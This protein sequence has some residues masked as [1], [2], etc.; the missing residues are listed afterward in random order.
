MHRTT[1]FWRP[2]VWGTLLA[3]LMS[4]LTPALAQDPCRSSALAQEAGRG[5]VLLVP[6]GSTVPLQLKSRK[7][8]KTVVNPKDNVIEIRTVGGDPTTVRITGLQ[9]G[10]TT[11]ELTDADERKE[12]YEVTVQQDVEYLKTLIRRVVPT[13]NV[14]PIPSANNAIILTGTVTRAEDIG[15]IRSLAQSLG[16]VQVIDGMRVGGVLQVQLDVVIASVSRT[17]TR[18]V[19]FDWAVNSQNSFFSNYVAGTQTLPGSVGSAGTLGSF[20]L[21]GL[22]ATPTSSSSFLFGV[23]HSGW[24]LLGFLQALK[25]EGLA[26]FLTQPSLV[27][28]SGRPAF[29]NV[30]GQQA[31]PVVGGIGGATGVS[32][33]P[34]G[35]QLTFLPIV[36]GNGK[37]YMEVAPNITDLDPAFGVVLAGN[38]VPGRRQE[39]V[40]TTV[41]LESGQTFVIG[42]LTRHVT[43]ANARKLPFLGELPFVG[44]FFGSRV[45]QDE[46]E[47]LVILVTPHLVD[48]QDCAQVAK[49]LPGQET[50]RAD[51]FE[52]YLEGILEA[53]RGARDVF[54]NRH[55]I[56]A[57]KNSPS[58]EVFPCAGPHINDA[59]HR[60]DHGPAGHSVPAGQPVPPP[61]ALH[62][63]SA[64]ACTTGSAAC[65]GSA[66]PAGSPES[67]SRSAH[68]DRAR[69]RRSDV[70]VQRPVGCLAP[71]PL[72]GC[73][74]IPPPILSPAG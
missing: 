51:D 54:Q 25:T 40:T 9:P 46:E 12:T 55:Y 44:N 13:S 16:G 49:V 64:G 14:T 6:I 61:P 10:V 38:V 59:G 7:P 73:A 68:P 22:T 4:G 60:R 71:A 69:S 50:R 57:Y 74:R 41:M 36:L 26:K 58:L 32:F 72:R 1:H 56:P 24:G 52:L 62:R 31:V 2:G 45:S 19:G 8:I 29:F 23:L 70:A 21:T 5:N 11:I 28:L 3:L 42:G 37:I 65:P 18:N 47:E 20:P 30:G 27:T 63:H 66:S 39:T 15:I 35:T 17:L 48:P 53:P 34:F 33:I 43:S 67:G